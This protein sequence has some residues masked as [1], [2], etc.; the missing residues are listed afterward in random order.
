MV[1]AL[2]GTKPWVAANGAYVANKFGVTSVG[3]LGPGS[4]PGSDHPLG[5][6]LDFM[7]NLALGQRI[8]ADFLANW[9]AYNVK[10]V[11]WNR[12]YWDSPTHH[13]PYIGPNP[14][15]DHVHVS[16][17]SAPRNASGIVGGGTAG[18]PTAVPAGPNPIPNLLNPF[19]F[20]ASGSL[21]VRIGLAIGGAILIII[22]LWSLMGQSVVEIPQ[23]IAKAV[24]TNAG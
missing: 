6:A 20:L 7:A 4:V 18:T 2:S 12:T 10:Y 21:W 23:K 15:L 19:Q 24:P 13:V 5:L 8:T 14:H 17:L 3:G 1:L 9:N 11:I 22:G 16:Y